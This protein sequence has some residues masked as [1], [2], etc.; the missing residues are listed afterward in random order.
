[1]KIPPAL[2]F[3]LTALAPLAAARS[4]DQSGVPLEVDAPRPGLAKIVILAGSLSS[5]PMAHEY[6]AGC[7][8][9]GLAASA[10]RRLAGDGA[11]LAEG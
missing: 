8:A 10:A 11:R 3:L 9:D 1:M 4:Y 7:A 6:F 5:K 2:F